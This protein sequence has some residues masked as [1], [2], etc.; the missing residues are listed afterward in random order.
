MLR[1]GVEAFLYWKYYFN[2][3]KDNLPIQCVV[4]ATRTNA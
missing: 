3:E 4:R 1:A 2:T